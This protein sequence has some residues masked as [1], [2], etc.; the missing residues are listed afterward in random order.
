MLAILRVLSATLANCRKASYTTWG[1]YAADDDI[2]V[3]A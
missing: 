3:P 1:T 2:N